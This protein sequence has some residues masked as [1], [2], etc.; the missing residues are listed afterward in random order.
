MQ[1]LSPQLRKPLW[2]WARREAR[3]WA[4]AD[5][6]VFQ[7]CTNRLLPHAP[8]YATNPSGSCRRGLA[9]LSMLISVRPRGLHICSS[10]ILNCVCMC[11]CTHA[12]THTHTSIRSCV[13]GMCLCTCEGK[14][15]TLGVASGL[16][17]FKRQNV[18]SLCMSS[19]LAHD[20]SGFFCLCLLSL[21]HRS[22]GI[23]CPCHHGFLWLQDIRIKSS[24]L[25]HRRS[26]LW[27]SPQPLI[28]ILIGSLGFVDYVCLPG[29]KA[30]QNNSEPQALDLPWALLVLG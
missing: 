10:L 3:A 2:G 15:R 28:L 26:S 13:S 27:S 6:G 30:R 1:A 14:R 5:V 25:P 19:Q 17:L 12:H 18:M 21:C 4:V 23:A 7:S 24:C 9:G 8:C 20:L 11:V 16:P 29:G 22:A